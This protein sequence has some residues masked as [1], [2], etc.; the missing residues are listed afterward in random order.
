MSTKKAKT[1]KV[2]DYQKEFERLATP[3]IKFLNNRHYNPHV[4]IIITPTDAE[5]L[6]GE[7]AFSTKKYVKD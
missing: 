6:C 4:T 1:T 5:L 7:M 2:N 3:L